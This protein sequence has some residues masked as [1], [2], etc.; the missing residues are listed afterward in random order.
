M[1][2]ECSASTLTAEHLL[3]LDGPANFRDVGGHPTGRGNALKVPVPCRAAMLSDWAD[4]CILAC[5][6]AGSR[7]SATAPRARHGGDRGA[8][9]SSTSARPDTAFHV[10]ALRF[11]RARNPVL[12]V[13]F[14]GGQFF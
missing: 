5:Y 10:A 1:R 13:G 14:I 3:N 2:S 4:E 8:M 9:A 6:Q 12:D 11:C 7:P